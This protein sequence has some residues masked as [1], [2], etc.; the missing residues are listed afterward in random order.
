M[1]VAAKVAIKTFLALLAAGSLAAVVAPPAR[2]DISGPCEATG[3]ES[4]GADAIHNAK[5]ATTAGAT[6][7]DI[8][9]NDVWHVHEGST[10]SGSGHA[11]PEQTQGHAEVGAFGISITIASGSGKG[12]DGSAGPLKVNDLATFTNR[13][14]VTGGSD[15]CSGDLLIVV[16]GKNPATT[17]AGGGGLALGVIGLGGVAGVAMRRRPV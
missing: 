10:L 11:T 3:Y 13:L 5:E 9:N 2:A 17:V 6:S 14:G 4:P 16:D 15:S 1:P 12:H 7:I 8:K